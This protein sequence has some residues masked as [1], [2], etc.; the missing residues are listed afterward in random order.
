MTK[1]IVSLI[2]L[3]ILAFSNVDAQLKS[4]DIVDLYSK[5]RQTELAIDSLLLVRRS[6]YEHSRSL[7]TRIDS[8]KESG[9]LY[10]DDLVT[11]KLTALPVGNR[12]DRIDGRLKEFK[13]IEDSLKG[14]LCKAHDV[15]IG[16]LLQ[17][18]EDSLREDGSIDPGVDVL[19][20]TI[21]N[22]RDS[23]GNCFNYGDLRFYDDISVEGE[24]GPDDIRLKIALL[25]HIGKEIQ[26][27]I[28]KIEKHLIRMNYR[29]ERIGWI[30]GR[31]AD[32]PERPRVKKPN[33][34]RKAKLGERREERKNTIRS[35]KRAG[36]ETTLDS[37]HGFLRLRI[38][39]TGSHM[40]ELLRM[41]R[42]VII[43]EK[44]LENI[45]S[46]ILQNER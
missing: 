15:E 4:N 39:K 9:D 46:Q 33:L 28:I 5:L 23:L 2:L 37:V 7:A 14:K 44:Q 45:L 12:L 36:F 40:D 20:A 19:F 24:D 6:V 41:Q 42:V 8:L 43:K 25:D 32:P 1:I 34:S 17:L 31:Q 29:S 26:R 38:K 11:E 3:E 21:R 13:S 16:V 10:L 22:K 30:T 27:K 35:L 18:M